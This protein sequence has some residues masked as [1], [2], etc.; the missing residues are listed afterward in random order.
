MAIGLARCGIESIVLER[1]A[2]P[3]DHS[4]AIAILPRTLM[5]F[6][7]W[8]II[9]EFLREATF[10]R[11]IQPFV[12]GAKSPFI[13]LDFDCI[14]DYTPLAGFMVLPQDRTEKIL[15][16]VA[17]DTKE[18]DLRY[19]HEVTGFVQQE[20][21]TTTTVQGP[22]G[23]Y[24]L[25]SEYLVGCDGPHSRVREVM[26]QHLEGKTYPIIA[27]LADV[28]IRDQRNEASWPIVDP[29]AAGLLA[30]IKF[31]SNTWRIIH[32]LEEGKEGLFAEGDEAS[33]DA[34]IERDVVRLFGAGPYEVIW[35]SVFRLH[36]RIAPN[37]RLGRALLAGDAAHLNSPAGGQGMNGGIQDAHNLAWKI[38]SALEGCDADPLLNSYDQE[39]RY[40]IT[41]YQHPTTDMLTNF[42]IQ[43]PPERRKLL[44]KLARFLIAVPTA[45]RRACLGASMLSAEYGQ[46]D[47]LNRDR[48]YVGEIMP[49]IALQQD[50]SLRF[51][52][53]FLYPGAVLA[54]FDREEENPWDIEELA[55]AP[56]KILRIVRP[57][58]RASG[59]FVR[60][61]TDSSWWHFGTRE[62]RAV[63]VRPDGIIGWQQRAPQHDE[64]V[65]NVRRALGR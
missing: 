24:S 40:S 25:A 19:G 61:A 10:K 58:T 5:V 51:L 15:A 50:G 32:P 60:T 8:G 53:E 12:A 45:M 2:E 23:P 18:I 55:K 21:G 28:V 11:V 46:S 33:L 31:E 30:A 57:K 9:G 42:V 49:D 63:L 34:E 7:S 54:L 20:S 27:M 3:S 17:R 65:S 43:A 59:D 62:T 48:A 44:V 29:G 52:Y 1:R 35:K 39:R 64:I 4:K 41:H 47:L 6:E 38:A 22:D 26:G 14:S 13:T 56:A 36:E 16:G 37:F